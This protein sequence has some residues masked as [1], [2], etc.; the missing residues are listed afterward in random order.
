MKIWKLQRLSAVLLIPAITWLLLSLAS[1][2]AYH[3]QQ[4]T[5]W[6]KQLPTYLSLN[7]IIIVTASHAYIGMDEVFTDYINDKKYTTA[8]K[9]LKMLTALLV[10][11]GIVS[12]TILYGKT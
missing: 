9:A 3:Y 12:L 1:L 8:I 2:E 10:L 6:I 5:Y 11:L 7:F 4:L